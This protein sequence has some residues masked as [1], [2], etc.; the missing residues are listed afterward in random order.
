AASITASTAV[1]DFHL[2]VIMALIAPSSRY[3][4]QRKEGRAWL[5]SLF[6]GP[7]GSI[8]SSTRRVPVEFASHRGAT[9]KRF[10]PAVALIAWSCMAWPALAAD[11]TMVVEL[12]PGKAPDETGNIGPEYVRMSPKL[13]KKEVEVTDS[14]RMVTN[15]TRPTITIYR[16]AKDKDTG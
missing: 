16:P 14:T 5:T 13:T 7:T 9:M 10:V 8:P 3:T 11:K 2:I 1:M 12:W 4:N 15:V 6:G